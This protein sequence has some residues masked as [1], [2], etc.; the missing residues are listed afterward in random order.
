MIMRPL[1]LLLPL[2]LISGCQSTRVFD[3]TLYYVDVPV[4]STITLHRSIETV[5]HTAG[6]YIQDGETGGVDRLEAFCRFELTTVSE[7]AQPIEADEFIV[8]DVRVEY[9]FLGLAPPH[10]V[11]ASADGGGGRTFENRQ[12]ALYLQPTPRNPNIYRLICGKWI[13]VI[14][15]DGV[16]IAEI[17]EVGGE[18][19]TLELPPG[20]GSP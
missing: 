9:E 16:S 17:R 1:A 2:A 14:D 10:T 4:G 11:L 15:M 6:V 13:E 3:E 8:R 12:A 20:V 7:E 18:L 19:F 5:P